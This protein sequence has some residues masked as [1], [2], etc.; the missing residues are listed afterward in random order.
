MQIKLEMIKNEERNIIKFLLI[1]LILLSFFHFIFVSL[2]YQ[3]QESDNAHWHYLGWLWYN[4]HQNETIQLID[5]KPPGIH[6]LYYLSTKFYG[7]NFLPLKFLFIFIKL[8]NVFLVYRITILLTSKKEI[9]LCIILINFLLLSWKPLDVYP[10]Y[11]EV[12]T[13]FISTLCIYVYLKIKYSIKFI[14][15]GFL[16]SLGFFFKQTT[17]IFFVGFLFLIYFLSKE[18]R[19]K[20]ILI[21]LFSFVV[22]LILILIFLIN[23]GLDLKGIIFQTFNFFNEGADVLNNILI[24][25]HFFFLRWTGPER[26]FLLLIILYLVYFFTY[27]KKNKLAKSLF[28]ILLLVIAGAHAV[29]TITGHQL[30]DAVPLFL[31]IFTILLDH[32]HKNINI[33]E[34][35]IF[36]ITVLIFFFPPINLSQY[37][38]DLQNFQLKDVKD[39]QIEEIKNYLYSLNLNA[40]DTVYIH[41]RDSNL[42]LQLQIRSPADYFNNVFLYK[43]YDKGQPVIKLID[44]VKRQIELKK[45]KIIILLDS[46]K[47]E[48]PYTHKINFFENILK[49]YKLVKKINKYKIYLLYY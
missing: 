34:K 49:E 12:V 48:A 35:F 41:E 16:F 40:N 47:R 19:N 6:F 13:S 1:F 46:Y 42:Q 45:P 29:G 24:R 43:S 32:C 4:F 31:I 8:V 37:K 18:S 38:R 25:V 39:T 20:N 36:I 14:F 9:Q 30:F 26:V 44:K 10:V 27:F 5:N 21:T 28:L 23:F 7:V 33:K 3:Q 22:F 17:L 15:I 2:L 11:T